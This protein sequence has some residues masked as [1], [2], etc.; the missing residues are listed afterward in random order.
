MLR[1][2]LLQ[3]QTEKNNAHRKSLDEKNM[4]NALIESK[5]ST[6]EQLMVSLD[7]WVSDSSLP[8]N[9]PPI[10]TTNGTS[11]NNNEGSSLSNRNT[12]EFYIGSK[13]PNSGTLKNEEQSPVKKISS[14][15]SSK[16]S[17]LSVPVGDDI[18]NAIKAYVDKNPDF[19]YQ[20]EK[21]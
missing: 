1:K 4:L 8:S 9:K 16:E 3:E 11:N 20:I 14:G 5:D 15:H 19:P 17:W 13:I 2:Q 12:Q 7:G 10:N 18:D 6:I 21:L